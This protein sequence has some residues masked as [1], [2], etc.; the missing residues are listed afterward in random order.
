MGCDQ[1]DYSRGSGMIVDDR[2]C[3]RYH[4]AGPGSQCRQHR[5]GYAQSGGQRPL[6]RW[7]AFGPT[8]LVSRC[9]AR[10]TRWCLI[11][12]NRPHQSR[13]RNGAAPADG[14]G[15][16]PG[17]SRL[18]DLASEGCQDT[19]RRGS[20]VRGPRRTRTSRPVPDSGRVAGEHTEPTGRYAGPCAERPR[21]DG[22]VRRRRPIRA[23]PSHRT[24][25][26]ATT[27]SRIRHCQAAASQ[28][29]PAI[30]TDNP[31]E[32]RPSSWPGALLRLRL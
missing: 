18:R 27:P 29:T 32:H 13:T 30:C 5:P 25:G 24:T 20:R 10:G 2:R 31:V 14:R 8:C 4:G 1:F 15:V 17:R 11:D 22:G 16:R 6:F 23:Q 26:I 19:H 7:A 3:P 12:A 9:R 21:H 28:P